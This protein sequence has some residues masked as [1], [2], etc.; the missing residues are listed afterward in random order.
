MISLICLYYP[1][2]PD[3]SRRRKLIPIS[4]DKLNDREHYY[5]MR[6]MS[7]EVW[8]WIE[9]GDTIV[10]KGRVCVDDETYRRL[11]RE[12]GNTRFIRWVEKDGS[13]IF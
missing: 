8:T 7:T 1:Y 2:N 6:K 4:A 3:G 11:W 13:K 5:G 9:E 10:W 12:R